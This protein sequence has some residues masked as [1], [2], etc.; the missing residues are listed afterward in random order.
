M[1]I[2]D[3]F[4]IFMLFFVQPIYGW[5]SFRR[6][7]KKI[8][9]GEP[10][11]RLSLYRETAVVEWV[12]LVILLTGWILLARPLTDLGFAV[13]AGSA[14][15][16]CAALVFIGTVVMIRS[17]ASV[18]RLPQSRR[19]KHRDSFGDLGHFLPQDD[20]ELKSFYRLSVTAGIVEEIVY[21]G[22]VLWYLATLMPIWPAVFVSSIGFGLCHSYQGLGGMIR[23]GLVGL[24]FGVLF[25]FSGSLW[26]PIIGHILLD[27]LQGKQIR[28]IYRDVDEPP[29]G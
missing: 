28:E 5:L 26:L 12:F 3:H 10:A 2:F 4:L 18:R 13:P 21:R 16:I 1:T 8:A 17:A 22:F 27:V 7:L 11:R 15:W 29:A 14:F 25:V 20:R 9:A 6:Y 24:A 19:V 23:T